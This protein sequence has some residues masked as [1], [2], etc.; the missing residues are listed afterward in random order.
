MQERSRQRASQRSKKVKIRRRGH[1][2]EKDTKRENKQ[3][4]A[5][6]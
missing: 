1:K 6:S 4:G 2:K 5:S 3:K